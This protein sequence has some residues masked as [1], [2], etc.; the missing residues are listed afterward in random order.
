MSNPIQKKNLENVLANS[1]NH[2][3]FSPTIL[4]LLMYLVSLMTA[5]LFYSYERHKGQVNFV[6][7]EFSKH[8]HWWNKG[9]GAG[10]VTVAGLAEGL[11]IGLIAMNQYEVM[12]GYRAKFVGLIILTMIVFVLLNTYLLRQLK[13]IGM[14]III[15]ILALYFIDM[16]RNNAILAAISPLS[17]IDKVFYNYLNAEHPVG[18]AMLILAVL[19]IIGFILNM[20]IKHFKKERL[21]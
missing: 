13:S 21:I 16:N 9:I 8:N 1:D 19:A 2:N 6:K 17:H 3:T 11:I 20:F 4:V 12:A 15:V 18:M 10:I 5:Y 14:F 7:D